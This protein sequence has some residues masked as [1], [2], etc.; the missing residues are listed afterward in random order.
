MVIWANLVLTTEQLHMTVDADGH[1]Y[2]SPNLDTVVLQEVE[3]LGIRALPGA[4]TPTE[5]IET[6]K[7]GA[8]TVKLF[9]A[10]SVGYRNFKGTSCAAQSGSKRC[11]RRQRFSKRG[12]IFTCRSRCRRT[13]G[14]EKTDLC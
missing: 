7:A 3:S 2:V 4:L 8:E 10:G 1:F 12:W 5:I 11:L 13:F 9:P 14:K 6:Y